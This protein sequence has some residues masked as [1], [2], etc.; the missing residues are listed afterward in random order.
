MT[1]LCITTWPVNDSLLVILGPEG[2]MLNYADDVY[3]GG[4][5]WNVALALDAAPSFYAMIG[6]S[7]G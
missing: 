6:L 7:L 5:P 2:F 1:I 3:L 4:V